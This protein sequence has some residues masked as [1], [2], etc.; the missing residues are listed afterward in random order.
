M[1]YIKAIEDEKNYVID[2]SASWCG[3]CKMVKPYFHQYVEEF[4]EIR[5]FS[6][7]GSLDK[8]FME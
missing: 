6:I 3:P 7:D 1:D 2:V 8:E 5:F 4:P